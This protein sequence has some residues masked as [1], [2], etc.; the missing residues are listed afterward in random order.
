MTE[1][2]NKVLTRTEMRERGVDTSDFVFM[3]EAGFFFGE[4]VLKA[5]ARSGMLRLFFVLEDG[6][7]IIS[8]VFW[9]QKY[10]GFYEMDNNVRLRLQYE[11]NSQGGIYLKKAE[12]ADAKEGKDLS[13]SASKQK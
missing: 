9:W 1:K 10:L 4:L 6:R 11:C 8:P 7:R 12:L 3:D 13:F 5:E 2:S